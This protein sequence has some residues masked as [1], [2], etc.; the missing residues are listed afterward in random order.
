GQPCPVCGGSVLDETWAIGARAEV[1][2]LAKAA[3]DADDAHSELEAATRAVR[4]LIPTEPTVL[5]ANL[6]GEIDPATA[7]AAWQQWATL[8]DVGTI[9]QLASEADGIFTSLAAAVERIRNDAARAVERHKDAWQPLAAAL[10]A[11]VDL[12][13]ASRR[14]ANTLAQLK[15][16]IS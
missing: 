2:R 5:S 3:R 1:A 12:A 15:K 4:H 11:W 9:Q 16:A 8:A 7:R 10:A 13:R 14:D 6:G